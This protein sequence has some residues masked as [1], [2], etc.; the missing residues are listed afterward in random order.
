[1][2]GGR[3]DR[4]VRWIERGL[5]AVGASC[6]LW[7]GAT[8]LSAI[9]YQVEHTASLERVGQ[10]LPRPEADLAANVGRK[11]TARWPA[12]AIRSSVRFDTYK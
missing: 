11:G 9:V 12:I 7:V 5:V 10:F 3:T 6:L 2:R 1:M 4:I 8:S